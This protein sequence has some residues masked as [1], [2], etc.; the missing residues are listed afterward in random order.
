[1]HPLGYQGQYTDPRRRGLWGPGRAGAQ[2]TSADLIP[3]DPR[4]L[5][6]HRLEAGLADRHRADSRA[7]HPHQAM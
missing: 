7:T 4:E 3:E 2:L 5:A 1:M 6:V